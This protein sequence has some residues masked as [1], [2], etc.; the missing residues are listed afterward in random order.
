MVAFSAVAARGGAGGRGGGGWFIARAHG[1]R[2]RY[3]ALLFRRRR[4]RDG[5]DRLTPGRGPRVLPARAIGLRFRRFR[6]VAAL[7]PILLDGTEGG[8]VTAVPIGDLG[9]ADDMPL[10]QRQMLA[11]VPV[12]AN[13]IQRDVVFGIG[14]VVRIVEIDAAQVAMVD[15]ELELAFPLRLL[16]LPGAQLRQFGFRHLVV[17]GDVVTEVE[18][19]DPVVENDAR[20]HTAEGDA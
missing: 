5:A 9:F 4:H 3:F 20:V 18:E 1:R 7:G 16:L 12:S 10:P 8:G 6:L 14:G 13:R 11:A 15:L 19:I 17:V 2:R